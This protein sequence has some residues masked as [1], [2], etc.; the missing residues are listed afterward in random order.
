MTAVAGIKRSKEKSK[1]LARYG[2][3]LSIALLPLLTMLQGRRA[4]AF[5]VQ[6]TPTVT[7]NARIRRH[8]CGSYDTGGSHSGRESLEWR[9]ALS[10]WFAFGGSW[11]L[12]SGRG[13]CHKSN[14]PNGNHRANAALRAC[15]LLM[16]ARNDENRS[17]EEEWPFHKSRRSQHRYQIVAAEAMEGIARRLE[18]VHPERFR[19]HKTSWGKFPD[20]TDNIEIGGFTPHNVV[21]GEHVLFLASFHNNDVTLSQFQVM[22]CLL[23]YF[24]ESLTVVLPYYPTGTMERVIKEGQVATANTY[25][26]MFSNLPSCGKPTRLLVYDLHT[27]QNRFYLHGNAIASLQTSIPILIDELKRSNVDCIA[28]PDDGAAKRFAHMFNGLDYHIVICGKVREN[29]IRRISIQDGDPTGKNIIIVD[30]LVQTGGTLY[31][32]GLALKAAGACAVS[33]FVAHGVFPKESWKRFLRGGDRAVFDKFMVT[34][35][36]PTTTDRLPRDDVY[37]VLDL[38]DRIKDDLDLHSSI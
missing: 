7:S 12:C 20:G 4:R 33:C 9:V 3:L 23:Q 5:V 35:S 31:E 22:I 8:L 25:A 1:C 24:V 13:G 14:G 19:F 18:E 34:N 38:V 32:C 27:L 26:Q 17:V 10:P 21:S 36:I 16:A 30:D 28:F 11:G 29:E 37:V 2:F 6:P 15:P